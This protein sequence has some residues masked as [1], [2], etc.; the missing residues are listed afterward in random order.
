MYQVQLP[1]FDGPL[2]LLLQLIEQQELDITTVALAQ[3]TDQYLAYLGVVQEIHPDE[4]ADFVT[5]AARLLL[6]KSR[7]L[8]PAPHTEAEEPEEDPGEDLVRRLREYRRF[9]RIA[10]VLELRDA[11]GLHNYPR[12]RSAAQSAKWEPRLVLTETTLDDLIAALQALLSEQV[13]AITEPSV[14]PYPVT[15]DD[16]IAQIKLQ[17]RSRQA[18]FF[19]ELLQDPNSRIEIIVTLLATLELIRS[20]QLIVRQEQ[21]FGKIQIIPLPKEPTQT[22]HSGDRLS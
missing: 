20:R 14:V 12:A 19:D 22:T 5:I 16:K 8:L 6:I 15:I 10:Q 3:V 2:D 9:K 1:V 7:A 4:L 17:L 21:L 11:E 18:L 13:D